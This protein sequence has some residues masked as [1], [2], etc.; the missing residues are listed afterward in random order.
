MKK[1]EV[2]GTARHADGNVENLSFRPDPECPGVFY[3]L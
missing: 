2:S 1:G 3:H